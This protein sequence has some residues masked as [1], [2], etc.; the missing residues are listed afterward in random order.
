M[1]LKLKRRSTQRKSMPRRR[2]FRRAART[3]Y[4][5]ARRI[6]RRRGSRRG[7]L[8]GLGG[9]GILRDVEGSLGKGILYQGVAQKF[10]PQLAPIAGLYGGWKGGGLTGLAVTEL[11]VKPFLGMP[12]NLGNITGLLGGLGL[13]GGG[14]MQ[15]MGGAV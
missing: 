8:G 1:R 12:S 13:G 14:Q 6:S 5:T 9:G 3:V 15:S 2:R 11:F 4:R 7:G 10:I